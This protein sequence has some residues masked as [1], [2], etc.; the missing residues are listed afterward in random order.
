[1]ITALVFGLLALCCLVLQTTF[2][3]FI[4]AWLGTPDLTFI[5]VVFVAYRLGWLQGLL[6]VALC[7][8][9]MDVVS[10]FYLGIY[11]VAYLLVFALVKGVAEHSPVK[12]GLYQIPMVGV[13]YFVVQLLLFGFFALI[14][15]E[16]LPS[17]RWSLVVRETVILLVAAIPC[18][19][20]FNTLM[21]GLSRRRLSSRV[22]V[23]RSGNRYRRG[24]GPWKS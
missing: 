7:G 18:F 17:W 5:L 10:G 8:W 1:M 15:P 21:D 12:E 19:L 9:F 22:M 11:P 20:L 16:A 14:Q 23:R 4:P 13:T 24:E 2:F 6:L 3:Q